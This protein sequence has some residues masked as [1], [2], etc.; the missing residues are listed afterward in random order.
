[1]ICRLFG[2]LLHI[3]VNYIVT[4]FCGGVKYERCVRLDRYFGVEQGCDIIYI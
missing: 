1:M 2:G 4:W 3:V